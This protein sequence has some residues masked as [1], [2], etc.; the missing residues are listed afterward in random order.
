MLGRCLYLFGLLLAPFY[1]KS[2]A[3]MTV[4]RLGTIIICESSVAPKQEGVTSASS[5]FD[6]RSLVRGTPLLASTDDIESWRQYVPLVVSC[7]VILDILLGSPFVNLVLSPMKR[8]TDLD[9]QEDKGGDGLTIKELL[10]QMSGGTSQQQQGNARKER[11]DSQKVAQEAID[12]AQN[13]ME[14]RDYLERQKTD[15]DKMEELRK[16]MDSQMV[17]LEQNL[18][19]LEKPKQSRLDAGD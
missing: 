11:V 10:Q 14:L 17:E 12:R 15:W 16:K 8:Q 6:Q 3:F 5:P 9:E 2:H 18:Q 4:Q 1:Q 13:A 7:F 19:N